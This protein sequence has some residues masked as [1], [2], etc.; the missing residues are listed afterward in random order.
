MAAS[1]SSL[2]RAFRLPELSTII[3][4]YLDPKNIYKLRLVNTFFL[5]QCSAHF[6]ITFDLENERR[7]PDLKKLA[8]SALATKE[9]EVMA[10]TG[11]ID[12]TDCEQSSPL[13]VIQSLK[14]SLGR[15][16]HKS[17]TPEIVSILNQCGNLRRLFIRDDSDP[18]I[19]FPEKQS[20]P[21]RLLLSSIYPV[22]HE[23]GGEREGGG[24][25]SGDGNDGGEQHLTFWDLLPLEGLLFDRLESLTIYVGSSVQLNLERL[26]ARLDRS[27]ATRNLRSLSIT[28]QSKKVSWE[29]FRDCICNLSALTTLRLHFF[30]IIYTSDPLGDPDDGSQREMVMQ[31]QQEAPA[32]TSLTFRLSNREDLDFKLAFMNLFPNVESLKLQ[33]LDSLLDK[34]FDERVFTDV[35]RQLPLQQSPLGQQNYAGLVEGNGSPPHQLP[36]PLLRSLDCEYLHA[37]DWAERQVLRHWTQKTPN[38]RFASLRIF[39]GDVKNGLH[40]ELSAHSVS[41]AQISIEVSRKDYVKELL[42]S[43]LCRNLEVLRL[44]NRSLDCSSVLVCLEDPSESTAVILDQVGSAPPSQPSISDVP[45]LRQ[46][47][48]FARLPWTQTLTTICF[49]TLVHSYSRSKDESDRSVTFLSSFLRLLPRLVDFEVENPIMDLSVFNGLGRQ[50]TASDDD[51]PTDAARLS[52]RPWL[53]RIKIRQSQYSK[54]RIADRSAPDRLA[55]WRRQLSYQ[56]RFL[57]NL[58]LDRELVYTG[59]G[60]YDPSSFG[61]SV[62]WSLYYD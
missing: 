13:D 43:R 17:L 50:S 41:L 31:Q 15:S 12:K 26:M 61:S 57:E 10:S 47:D 21:A 18:A 53:T 7:Y 46:Q 35:G 62:D 55:P 58:V 37:K 60:G 54:D 22:V 36:F 9:R 4:Q 16:P 14:V 56:F 19:K 25:G 49:Q 52:E 33:S 23:E 39:D 20:Y 42:R 32:V 44:D 59:N 2:I 40:E 27:R 6:S 24:D 28:A 34:K 48:L 5:D 29:V 51:D 11:G 1:E 38:F 45:L 30:Q 3:I 8:E